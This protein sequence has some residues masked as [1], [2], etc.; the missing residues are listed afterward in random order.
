MTINRS[1]FAKLLYPGLSEV[2]GA[3]YN[4]YAPQYKDLYDEKSSARAYEEDMQRIT[5]G[6]AQR[7]KEGESLAYDDQRQGYVTRYSHISYALGFIITREMMDDDLYGEIGSEGAAALAWSMRQ[8]KDVEGADLYNN[9]FLA[10]SNGA[11]GRPM[12]DAANEH[13]SG[14]TWS[15]YVNADLSEGALESACIQMSKWTDD[16]GKRIVVQPDKIVVP[17]DLEFDIARLMKSVGRTAAGVASAT[18]DAGTDAND[19]NAITTLGKFPGGYCVNNYFTNAT[20]WFIRNK[21]VQKGLT[22]Y[23]RVGVE[24]APDN[25]FDTKNAKFSAYERYSFG[26][27]DKRAIFGGEGS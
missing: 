14:G 26:Y 23:N 19:I 2:W 24:F 3:K 9:A 18:S 11:D 16:R 7:K 12:C 10:G 20:D 25:D 13:Y 22:C 6:L 15:N 1:N 5:F 4:E 27:S 8:T 21:G 17:A